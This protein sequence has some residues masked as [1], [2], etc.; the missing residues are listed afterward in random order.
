ML[1]ADVANVDLKELS[2]VDEVDYLNNSMVLF[3]GDKR[4]KLTAN[5]GNIGKIQR[6]TGKGELQLLMAFSRGQFGITDIATIFYNAK[7]ENDTR[8]NSVEQLGDA[9]LKSKKYMEY[10]AACAGFLSLTMS[11]GT[12]GK[13][14][15]KSEAAE[16]EAE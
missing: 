4:L 7:D 16:T 2:V 14:V 12:E 5:F 1:N 9:I 6:R 8:F 3:F 11:D 15:G 10:A 13:D